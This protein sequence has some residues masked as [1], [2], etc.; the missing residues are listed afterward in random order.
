MS[1][2]S[3]LVAVDGSRHSDDDVLRAAADRVPEGSDQEVRGASVS[4]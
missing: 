4:R 3:V 2:R 1:F